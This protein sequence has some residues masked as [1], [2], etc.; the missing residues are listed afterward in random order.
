MFDI[1]MNNSNNNNIIVVPKC[2][3]NKKIRLK[4]KWNEKK[5][6]WTWDT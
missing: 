2:Q 4:R 6:T 1:E 3:M 5:N